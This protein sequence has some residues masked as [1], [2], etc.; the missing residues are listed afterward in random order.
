MWRRRERLDSRMSGQYVGAAAWV[1]FPRPKPD[2]QG[3][4]FAQNGCPASQRPPE[5]VPDAD[6]TALQR[7]RHARILGEIAH[8]S[9]RGPPDA[10]EP[11]A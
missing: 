8:E 10:E 2:V 6:K 5:V 3:E 1:R 4:D 9:F 11:A 7:G